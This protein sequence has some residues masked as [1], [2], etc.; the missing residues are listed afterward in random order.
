MKRL[1]AT[2]VRADGLA[3]LVIGLW[4]TTDGTANIGIPL[5]GFGMFF[6]V[7]GGVA[8]H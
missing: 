1:V 2:S 5:L 8:P 3:L 7:V 4:L 6:L